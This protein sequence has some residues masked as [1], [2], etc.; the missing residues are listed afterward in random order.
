M[1]YALCFLV[2]WLV[3]SISAMGMI[4][5]VHGSKTFDR[6]QRAP[7]LVRISTFLLIGLLGPTYVM[8]SVLIDGVKYFKEVLMK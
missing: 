8:A 2:W 6:I 4:S 1:T 7:K 5:W 3:G